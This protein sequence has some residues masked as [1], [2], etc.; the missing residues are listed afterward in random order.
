MSI[1][2]IIYLFIVLSCSGCIVGKFTG[3]FTKIQTQRTQAQERVLDKAIY[4]KY[5][6]EMERINI[7]RE[8][9]GLKSKPILSLEQWTETH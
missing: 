8:R 6:L 5:S 4:T 2:I 7:N 9:A 1:R 3:D